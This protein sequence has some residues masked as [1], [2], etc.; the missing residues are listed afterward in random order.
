M[1]Y[2]IIFIFIFSSQY[3]QQPPMQ[4]APHVQQP[5][6]IQSTPPLQQA[7]PMQQS[8]IHIPVGPPST[9]VSTAT[10]VPTAYPSAPGNYLT[11]NPALLYRDKSFLRYVLIS[12]ITYTKAYLKKKIPDR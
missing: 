2:L 11:L 8:S 3:A 12:T 6:H 5:V 4:Q 10:I 1:Y 7:P 9:K